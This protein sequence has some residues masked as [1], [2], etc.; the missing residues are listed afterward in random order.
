MKAKFIQNAIRV[1]RIV[2]AEL[3]I[4]GFLPKKIGRYRVLD[5]LLVWQER[6]EN[7]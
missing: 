4:I 5:L 1:L 2:Y 6:V 7:G 3:E